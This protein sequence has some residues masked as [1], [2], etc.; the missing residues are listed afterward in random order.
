[1]F[2]LSRE[3]IHLTSAVIVGGAITW[4]IMYPGWKSEPVRSKIRVSLVIF[5]LI[6]LCAVVAYLVP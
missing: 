6:V 2:D 4:L 1:M 5:S 3:A